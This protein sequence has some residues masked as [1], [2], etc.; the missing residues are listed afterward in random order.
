KARALEHEDEPTL[1]EL[2][3]EIRELKTMIGELKKP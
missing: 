2:K 3:V 1:A